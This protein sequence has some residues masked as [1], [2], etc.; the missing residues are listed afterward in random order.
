MYSAI[1]IVRNSQNPILIVIKAP[2]LLRSAGF[3]PRSAKELGHASRAGHSEEESR[4]IMHKP[5]G[6]MYP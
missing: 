4:N 5:K 2:A 1:L 3:V 6:S